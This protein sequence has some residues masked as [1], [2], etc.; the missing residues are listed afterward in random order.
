MT[1]P[2]LLLR[3][4]GA[5]LFALCLWLYH[6]YA[7]GGWGLFLLLLLV[8]DLSMV[9]YLRGPRVGA[10]MYNAIHW[11]VPP[12]ILAGVVVA[13][14]HLELLRFALIW[15]AHIEM[16]RALGYGLKYPDDF[17]HTHLS[18]RPVTTNQN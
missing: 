18:Y 7:H 9:G 15:L 1:R 13:S 6:G 2:T 5:V 14:G 17:H 3:L 12:A 8:P 4:E 10:A 16:D 11:S